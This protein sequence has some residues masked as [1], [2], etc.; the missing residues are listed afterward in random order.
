MIK[1]VTRKVQI[2]ED[3]LF[4]LSEPVDVKNQPKPI[5]LQKPNV[6]WLRRK[7]QIDMHKLST[8]KAQIIEPKYV[9]TETI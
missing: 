7:D 3:D 6:S 8:V 2:D 5:A 9:C 1:L 4:L